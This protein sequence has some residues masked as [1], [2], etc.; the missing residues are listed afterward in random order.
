M[1]NIGDQVTIKNKGKY[2]ECSCEICPYI[3][4]GGEAIVRKFTNGT[5]YI[6]LTVTDIAGNVHISDMKFN[7]DG[8]EL[9]TPKA[10]DWEV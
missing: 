9:V 8:L 4:E 1:F 7:A 10:P 5:A 6:Y 3:Q 2:D